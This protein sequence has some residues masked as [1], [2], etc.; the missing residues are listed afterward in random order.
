MSS[1]LMQWV[2]SKRR[3][4]EGRDV[5]NAHRL[6]GEERLAVASADQRSVVRRLVAHDVI[7]RVAVR[8]HLASLCDAV[9]LRP[10]TANGLE[11]SVELRRD[12]GEVGVRLEQGGSAGQGPPRPGRRRRRALTLRS[13]QLGDAAVQRLVEVGG[14][15]RLALEPGHDP[16]AD[17]GDRGLDLTEELARPDELNGGWLDWNG[18]SALGSE[19]QAKLREIESEEHRL[20]AERARDIEDMEKLADRLPI[21]LRRLADVDAEI[22]ALGV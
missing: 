18:H 5:V 8:V 11:L 7:Q 21:A 1:R 17:P 2:R 12:A 16:V 15:H 6:G 3:Y 20:L 22:A 19:K 4:L 13:D 9:E 14:R 10:I